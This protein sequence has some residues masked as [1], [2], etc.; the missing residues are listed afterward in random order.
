V[1]SEGIADV[2]AATAGITGLTEGQVRVAAAYY[3]DHRAEVDDRI[4]ANERAVEE[5]E[6]AWRRQQEIPVGP[7]RSP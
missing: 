4:A 3:A 1:Q 5:F 7:P 6:A 2:V